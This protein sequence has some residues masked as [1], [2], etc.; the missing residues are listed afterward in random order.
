MDHENTALVQFCID[1][2]LLLGKNALSS[3]EHLRQISDWIPQE[4]VIIE[5]EELA[6]ELTANQKYTICKQYW[7]HTAFSNDEKKA[8]R[9]KALAGDSSD[10]AGNCRNDLDYSLPDEALKERLWTEILDQNTSDTLM[11]LRLKIQGFW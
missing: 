8:L 9:D 6:F 4:K 7:A 3:K 10:A 2:A 11:E 5:G 1:E